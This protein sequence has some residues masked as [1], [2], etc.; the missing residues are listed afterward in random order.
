MSQQFDYGFTCGAFDLMHA[1]HVLMLEEAKTMCKHLIVGI[2]T[3]P[4]IDRPTKNKPVE[5][6]TERFIRLKSVKY[7]DEVIP[8]ATEQDLMEMLKML[9]IGV[10]IVGA[11]YVGKDFTGK[12]Y[13]ED[14]DIFI[15]YNNRNHSMSS[16]D[17]RKRVYSAVSETQAQQVIANT[18][19]SY[20]MNNLT[21]NFDLYTRK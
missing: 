16:S 21:P 20:P 18:V 1:G 10:R 3:D 14:N 15:Y 6:I 13:C 12:Q 4:T 17:I 19:P 9:P 7:V 5:S 2:Q 11:D 8:Y